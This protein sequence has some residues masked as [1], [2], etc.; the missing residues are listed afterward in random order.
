[1][2]DFVDIAIT[3]IIIGLSI[4]CMVKYLLSGR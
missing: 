2:F 1:M 3:F 4:A